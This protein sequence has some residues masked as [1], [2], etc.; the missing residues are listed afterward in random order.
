M[1]RFVCFGDTGDGKTLLCV[2]F[3][4]DNYPE[5]KVY[6]NIHLKEMDYVPITDT[7]FID[8]IDPKKKNI[9]FID[10]V[11]EITRGHYQFTFNSLVSQSRKSIGENQLFFMTTQTQNQASTILKGMVDFFIFPNIVQREEGTNRPI[12]IEVEWYEK[13]KRSIPLTFSECTQR[14]PVGLT[15]RIVYDTC[16]YYDTGEMVEGLADGRF[17]KYLEK[18]ESFVGTTKNIKNLTAIINEKYGVSLSEAERNARKIIFAKEFNLWDDYIK[19][20]K[21]RTPKR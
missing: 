11:G 21:K 10:E 8:E 18:Y 16:D 14:L 7:A 3:I 4:R 9:V 20:K 6:S 12:A 19:W 5:Y 13:D 2:D 1:T 17:Y 15:H